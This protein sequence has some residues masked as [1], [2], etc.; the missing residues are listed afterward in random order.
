[1]SRSHN[2]T[3]DGAERRQAPRHPILESFSLFVTL[4]HKG[5]YRLAVHDVSELGIGF[6]FDTEGEDP[7]L[8]PLA[9][10][11]HL[12]VH[13]YLNQTL[14]LPL[15][16]KVSRVFSVGST[17]RVGAELVAGT[18]SRQAYLSFLAMLG[19]LAG[20]AKVS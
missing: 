9:A 13:L 2:P 3:G 14:Y 1:M 19:E 12:E 11:E 18:P 5:G 15:R 8:F 17:R 10:G 16:V 6:D 4:P 20:A 7:S